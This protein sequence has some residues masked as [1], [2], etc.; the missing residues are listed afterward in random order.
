VLCVSTTSWI[1]FFFLVF[2]TCSEKSPEWFAVLQSPCRV[3]LLSFFVYKS[4]WRV[5][6]SSF[7]PHPRRGTCHL[8]QDPRSLVCLEGQFRRVSPTPDVLSHIALSSQTNFSPP[9][10]PFSP[11]TISSHWSEAPPLL[12]CL[13]GFENN[14]RTSFHFIPCH[15]AP[16][17]WICLSTERGCVFGEKGGCGSGGPAPPGVV[18]GFPPS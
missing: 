11:P 13:V 10:S 4:T 8:P 7:F 3:L 16:N 9:T 17:A 5:D 1:C 15:Y 6:L 18:L 14:N 12:C 2:L